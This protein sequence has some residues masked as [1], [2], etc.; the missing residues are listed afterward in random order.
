MKDESLKQFQPVLFFIMLSAC[1]IFCFILLFP[2]IH[3]IG[4]AIVLTVIAQPLHKRISLHIKNPSISSLISCLI[5]VSII[6]IP[7]IF[8]TIKVINEGTILIKSLQIS[9]SED[10]LVHKVHF[11]STPFI[12]VIYEGLEKYLNI[13]RFQVESVILEKAE[14]IY[15]LLAQQS[16]A[17][18]KNLASG[19]FHLFII[20][21]TFFFLLRDFKQ[22]ISF[23]KVFIPLDER[24]T[25]KLLDRAENTIF[26]TVSVGVIVALAQ[27]SLGGLA[28]LFLGLPSPLL[29]GM[30]MVVLCL[31]PF[32]GA[33]VVWLPAALYL[34][35][36]GI[37][38]KA[39]ILLLWGMFVIGLADNLIR[40]FIIG[41]Q[42]KLHPLLV[43]FSVFGGVVFMGPLGLFMGP[44]I[45]VITIFLADI[46][47]TKLAGNHD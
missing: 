30:V 35:L 36:K 9:I 12:R 2:F 13:S 42:T 39:I 21:I 17:I 41:S 11:L 43:F 1:L 32:L 40:S 33:P 6:V 38:W 10:G 37:Y 14:Q 23:G 4:W 16:L 15:S 26:T 31:I 29:W 5:I 46:L 24:H 3:I 7:G 28:F 18:L 25:N 8:L 22:L 34:I 44:L 27:G 45:L 19:I 20:L 47:K